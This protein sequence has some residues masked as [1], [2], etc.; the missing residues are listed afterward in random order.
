MARAVLK[1][2]VEEIDGDRDSQ[3]EVGAGCARLWR[4]FEG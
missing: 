1:K 2:I 3:K 4:G